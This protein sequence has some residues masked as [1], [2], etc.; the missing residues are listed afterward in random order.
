[1]DIVQSLKTNGRGIA[2]MIA[3]SLVVAIGQLLWKMGMSGEAIRWF[4]LGIGCAF[5]AVGAFLMMAAFRYGRLS[6]LQPMLSFSYVFSTV[7]GAI[8]LKEICSP[9]QIAGILLIMAGVACI[10]GGDR[11]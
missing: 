10:G 2:L 4:H 7:L 8:V 9:G 1:M 11:E 6:V 3:S 5:Y